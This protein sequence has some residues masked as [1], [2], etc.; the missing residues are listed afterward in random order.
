VVEIGK[1]PTMEQRST[2]VTGSVD[3]L[4]AMRDFYAER[5][6][7]T[8]DEQNSTGYRYARTGNGSIIAG[9]GQP[10]RFCAHVGVHAPRSVRSARA[11]V[12]QSRRNVG[13]VA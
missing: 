11:V 6:G 13:G 9:G 10:S 5:F 4:A 1:K 8:L 2:I 12:R 3:D 7:W